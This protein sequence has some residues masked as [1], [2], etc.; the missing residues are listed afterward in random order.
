MDDCN[1]EKLSIK[2]GKISPAFKQDVIEYTATVQSSVEKVTLDTLTRDSGASYTI[3][4][5][6]SYVICFRGIAP[7]D[8]F[9][10]LTG[11]SQHS[12]T[13]TSTHSFPAP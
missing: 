6:I 2:P 10:Q 8:I 9:H 12:K 11:K 1:L 13:I 3:S 4:V 7:C 5:C